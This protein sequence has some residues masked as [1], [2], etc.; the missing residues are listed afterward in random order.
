MKSF[1]KNN[2]TPGIAVIRIS[3]M[4]QT[5]INGQIATLHSSMLMPVRPFATNRLIAKGGVM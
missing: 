5:T 3:P 4:T 2:D 1:G